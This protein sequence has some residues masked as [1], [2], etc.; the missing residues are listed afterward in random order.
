MSWTGV[1]AVVAGLLLGVLVVFQVAL[2]CGVDW[3]R[4]AYG[5]RHRR[6]PARLRV[7]SAVAAVLWTLVALLFL[8]RVGVGVWVPL[9]AAAGER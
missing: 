3:G 6:L 1:A 9:P 5:G 2:A 7:A 4:A 8:R